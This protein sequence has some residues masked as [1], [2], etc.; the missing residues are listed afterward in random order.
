MQSDSGYASPRLI[1]D[2]G[3]IKD[4]YDQELDKL[5]NLSH[6]SQEFLFKSRE[7]PRT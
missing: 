1:R 3:V 7:T 6:N 5:R 2:G 4:G